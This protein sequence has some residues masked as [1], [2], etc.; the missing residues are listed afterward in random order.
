MKKAMVAGYF[1]GLHAGHIRFFEK[2]SQYGQ[3]IVGIGSDERLLLVKKVQPIFAEAV[4][5]YMIDSCKFVKK[6]FI[7]SQVNG[8]FGVVWEDELKREKPD[9]FVVN[10]DMNTATI[11]G[12]KTICEKHDEKWRNGV[13][14]QRYFQSRTG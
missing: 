9:F 13:F 3:L 12:Q 1:D 11:K 7:L 8:D 2:A 4:R 5:Q 6:S 14:T 10:N